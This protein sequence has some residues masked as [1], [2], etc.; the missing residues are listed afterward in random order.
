MAAGSSANQVECPVSPGTETDN[1]KV[2]VVGPGTL[3]TSPFEN[4]ER[5]P[6]SEREVLIRP[7]APELPRPRQV[8]I[9]QC[10][11]PHA[12]IEYSGHQYIAPAYTDFPS[13]QQP[14]LSEHGIDRPYLLAAATYLSLGMHRNEV[15]R[16]ISDQKREQRACVNEQHERRLR[17]D[18]RDR[19]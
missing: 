13:Q 11:T 8:L 19:G 17:A 6:V 5:L 10:L 7:V 15:I 2:M 12:S 1:S 14:Q 16:I 3:S 9:F 18:R 4:S